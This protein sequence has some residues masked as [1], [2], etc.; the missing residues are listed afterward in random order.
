[1]KRQFY[2]LASEDFYYS[3]HIQIIL[4]IFIISAFEVRDLHCRR[5]INRLFKMSPF[6]FPGCNKCHVYCNTT[7][8]PND[9]VWSDPLTPFVKNTNSLIAIIFSFFH[10][11]IYSSFNLILSSTS[12]WILMFRTPQVC[13]AL[14][15]YGLSITWCLW[16][17]LILTVRC[18]TTTLEDAL[19]KGRPAAVLMLTAVCTDHFIDSFRETCKTVLSHYK[20]SKRVKRTRCK[21]WIKHNHGV[22]TISGVLIHSNW[23]HQTR[24]TANNRTDAMH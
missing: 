7:K 15:F 17:C 12:R 11:S 16:L 9:S 3:L 22:K 8:V 2:Y 6:V 10:I 1:M 5:L 21:Y 18:I 19:V 23:Q 13:S 4:T 20:K 24:R 14:F